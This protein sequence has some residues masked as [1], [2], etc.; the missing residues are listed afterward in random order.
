MVEKRARTAPRFRRVRGGDDRTTRLSKGRPDSRHGAR[1]SILYASLLGVG[2]RACTGDA[3]I[4]SIEA[5]A[6]QAGSFI[7]A[8]PCRAVVAA[9][10]ARRR[11]GTASPASREASQ[12]FRRR[13]VHP[14]RERQPPT[15]PRMPLTMRC[16]SLFVLVLA[17]TSL[18]TA[19]DAAAEEPSPTSE[20]LPAFEAAQNYRKASAFLAARESLTI[21]VQASC[22]AVVRSKCIEWLDEVRATQPSIVVTVKDALGRDTSEARVIVDGK[23]VR[24]ELDGTPIE[25]DP[26]SHELRIEHGDESPRTERV[27]LAEGQK[28]REI[29][30]SFQPATSEQAEGGWSPLL[31]VGAGVAA[32][33]VIVGAVTGGL[34]LSEGAKLDEQCPDRSMCREAGRDSYDTGLALSHVSTVGFVVAGAGAALAVVGL[35]LSDWDTTEASARVRLRVG[36][37]GASLQGRF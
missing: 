21:C 27:V 8:F 7:Q 1:D 33:G 31:F 32:V 26:G 24:P 13:R 36:P 9:L 15:P 11:R 19:R 22:P 6:S 18:V 28:N 3:S 25:L 2:C 34:A 10:C 14:R 37:F 5:I 30:I 23:L 35:L 16:K 17:L 29:A 20:C 4:D 12:L